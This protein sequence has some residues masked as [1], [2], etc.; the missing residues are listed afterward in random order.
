MATRPG[1]TTLLNVT[2]RHMSAGVSL[3]FLNR[4]CALVVFKLLQ[5]P[6]QVAAVGSHHR[7]IWPQDRRINGQG[8]FVVGAGAGQV[9]QV[10]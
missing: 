9:A 6:V 3:E 5:D 1:T 7:V 8:P 10:G 2:E 4:A